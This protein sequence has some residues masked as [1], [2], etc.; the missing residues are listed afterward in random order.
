[1]ASISFIETSPDREEILAEARDFIATCPE[2]HDRTE[3]ELPYKTVVYVC[4][5]L[6]HA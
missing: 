5:N 6:A 4:E 1:M 3:F 2:T